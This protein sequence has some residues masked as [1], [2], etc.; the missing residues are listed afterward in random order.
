M[1]VE[2]SQT[3]IDEHRAYWAD[4]AKNNGWYKE[5]F[6]VQVWVD[7]NGSVVDSVSY[8]GLSEDIIVTE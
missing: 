2:V 8:Q 6:Y 1:Q 4:I 7:D 3:S 5:P